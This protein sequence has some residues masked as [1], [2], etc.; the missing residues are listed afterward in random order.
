LQHVFN[1][2]TINPEKTSLH[3]GGELRLLK[4]IPLRAGFILQPDEPFIYTAGVGLD[5]RN[6]SFSAASAMRT[7]SGLESIIPV[8]TTAGVLHIR[9]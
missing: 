1:S 2:W 9:F 6:V 5:F 7:R 8:L 4:L 3:A